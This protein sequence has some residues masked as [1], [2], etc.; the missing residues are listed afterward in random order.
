M[1]KKLSDFIVKFRWGFIA[2][3]IVFVICVQIF[4]PSLSKVASS[5]QESFLPPDS[6]PI[7]ANTLYNQL[8]P[9]KGGKCSLT[10]VFENKEGL[11]EQDKNYMLSLEEFY[12]K[13]E[14]DYRI[15]DIVSP[16]S[17]KE[18]ENY[19]ISKDKKAAL[20]TIDLSVKMYTEE[21]DN[22]IITMRDGLKKDSDRKIEGMPDAPR[23][24]SVNIT[25]DAAIVQEEHQTVNK[26]MEITA[27]ITIVLLVVVLLLI[28][29][30][31]IAPFVP[32]I[33]IGISFLISRGVVAWLAELGLNVSSFTETF[34]IAVLFGAG[35]DYCLLIISRFREEL[36]QGKD[37]TEALKSAVPSTGEAIISSAGTVII[38]FSMMFFANF[39]LYKTTGPSVGIGVA[40][41]LLA[42]M[43]LTPSIVSV[44]GEK[45]FWPARPSKGQTG[46]KQSTFWYKLSLLVTQKPTRFIIVCLIIFVPFMIS[47]KGLDR[48]FDQL[49][50]L[51]ASAD[52]VKGFNIMSEHFGQGEILP[53]RVVIKS[54][55]NL[56]DNKSLQVVEQISQNV[57]KIDNV[58]KVRSATRPDGTKRN[59]LTVSYFL[60]SISKEM[61]NSQQSDNT[62]NSLDK[63]KD[64]NKMADNMSGKGG[65]GKLVDATGQTIQGISHVNDGLESL[66]EGTRSA[67]NGLTAINGGLEKLTTGVDNTAQGIEKAAAAIVNAKKSL[68]GMAKDK[69]EIVQD[70]NYQTALGTVAGVSE[71][72]GKIS[73]GL[74]DIKKG[75]SDSNEGISSAKDGLSKV[76]EGIVKSSSALNQ[77]Q[78][79]L[80]QIRDGQKLAQDEITTA[81]GSLKE[82]FSG[83][84]NSKMDLDKLTEGLDKI[85]LYADEYY[86]AHKDSDSTFFMPANAEE[87]EPGFKDFKNAMKGYISEDS[88]GMV[89]DVVL[90]IPPYKIEALDTSKDIKRVVEETLKKSYL[91][92]STMHVGGISAT[93]DHVRD[94][95]AHDFVKLM[96]FVLIGIFIVLCLLLRSIIAPFYLLLTIVISYATTMGISF[97]VFQVIMGYEG[98]SWSTTFFAFCLLV[99]LGVDYNIFLISRVK[100]EY[101]P[102]DVTGGVARALAST[103]G[104]ITSCGVIMAGTFGALLA[105]PIKPL[106]EIG[107]A[108]VVGLLMDTFIVRSLFVPAIAVKVGELNWWPGRKVKVL[109]R[110]E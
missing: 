21:S 56:L 28:Y 43:T 92:G 104:I 3:W 15:S 42:V 67:A 31:P 65:F 108:A 51:P 90:S 97:I 33:T 25:G 47:V 19:M 83:L 18:F 16:V 95:T 26:S 63:V 24:L 58:A 110:D 12:R 89:L 23:G 75:M 29:R 38:G 61:D 48:S 54:D 80:E 69:P 1:L 20:M 81:M 107:F 8:F 88:K 32:L 17:K 46:K 66:G 41:T 71:N 52:C 55:K 22:L 53:V 79:A 73:I 64:I 86:A 6:D 49:N 5:N 84:D 94:I 101:K 93:F 44:L 70:I 57:S 45:I 59:E 11:T 13:H 72:M 76:G 68:E 102:G 105:S 37:K 96:L 60:N 35:T 36:S 82:A 100:E 106:F 103:G 78:V 74:R 99:A 39:G 2:F 87:I 77:V 10:L 40:I 62:K 27:I 91:D 109:A 85:K 7:K 30:S 14:K 4:A 9:A 50:E 34:L 98:L